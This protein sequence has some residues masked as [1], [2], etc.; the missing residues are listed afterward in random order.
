ML[1][2][3]DPQEEYVVSRIGRQPVAL[4]TGVKVNIEQ[5]AVEGSTVKVTG[6][7]GTLTRTFHPDIDVQMAD[8]QVVVS[9]P[10]DGRQHKALHGLTRALINNMVIGVT[11][12]FSKVLEIMGVG[13][14]ASLRG[15]NLVLQLG[16]SHAVEIVAPPGINLSVEQRS[17]GDRE[18]AGTITV[19]GIDK[20][21]VGQVAA[22]IRA[23]RPPEPYKGKG[24]RYRGE[25][26]RR[27]AGKAGKLG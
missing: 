26:V 1:A 18:L 10:S 4:P 8:G 12:G 15:D 24:V 9:R 19:W 13:Y 7:N 2:G 22:E 11:Q 23:W 3:N 6:P 5:S 27:K 14:R 25:Y 16:H 21:L 17:R 20:Q